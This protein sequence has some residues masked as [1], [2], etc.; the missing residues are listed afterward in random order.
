MKTYQSKVENVWEQTHK[1]VYTEQ[2]QL[3][4]KSEKDEDKLAK[5]EIME[6]YKEQKRTPLS[7]TE[8]AKFIEIYNKHKPAVKETDKYELIVI[9]VLESEKKTSGIINYRMNGEQKQLRF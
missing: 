3:I 1:I 9:S 8:S 6:L 7:E 2:E 4:M 5:K